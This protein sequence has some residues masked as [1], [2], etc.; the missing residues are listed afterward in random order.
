M[1]MRMS[2]FTPTGVYVP[3]SWKDG[4]LV[5]ALAFK[6]AYGAISVRVYEHVGT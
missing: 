6:G 5:F 3:A 1:S 2:L 4:V